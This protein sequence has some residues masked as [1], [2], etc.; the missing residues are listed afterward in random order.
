MTSINSKGASFWDDVSAYVRHWLNERYDLS[1][2]PLAAAI[3]L[4]FLSISVEP[5]YRYPDD[6]SLK[7]RDLE[8]KGIIKL[9]NGIIRM[10]YFFV[11]TFMRYSDNFSNFWKIILLERDF[12]WQDWEVFNRDYISLRLSLYSYLNYTTISLKDFFS[13]AKMNIPADIEIKIPSLG[14][15]KNLEKLSHRYPSTKAPTF[16]IGDNVLNADGA[17]FDS[18]LYLETTADPILLAFQ[19]KYANQTSKSPQVINEAIVN[20]EFTKINSAVTNYLPGTN[21]VCI[22]LGF[23]EGTFDENKLPNNC[24]VISKQEQLT[25]Y[26]PSYYHRLHNRF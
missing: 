25:F 10:P 7:Y 19:M 6:R 2:F 26:G 5:S 24:V 8:E 15:L 14:S 3:A 21:F 12:W 17:P 18:F 13:G 11:C 16:E 1:D 9:E 20:K 4:S 23:Y 22:I